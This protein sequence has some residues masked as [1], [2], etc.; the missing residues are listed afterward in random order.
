MNKKNRVKRNTQVVLSDTAHIVRGASWGST[1]V[2]KLQH[3]IN[4]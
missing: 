3:A 1:H 2:V 4:R